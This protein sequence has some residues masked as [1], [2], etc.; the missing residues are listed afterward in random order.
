MV[1]LKNM[2]VF[3]YLWLLITLAIFSSCDDEEIS[4][5][6][7]EKNEIVVQPTVDNVI[8]TFSGKVAVLAGSDEF[9]SFLQKR[10]PRVE[11]ELTDETDVILMNEENA[12]AL[13]E[14][15]ERYENLERFWY[16]NKIVAFIRPSANALAL[17][18]KLQNREKEDVSNEMIET[19]EKFLVYAAKADGN[20]YSYDKFL[21]EEDIDVTEGFYEED[22]NGKINEG[23][24]QGNLKIKYVFNDFNKGQIAEAICGWLNKYTNEGRSISDVAFV[25]SGDNSMAS[26]PEAVTYTMAR[27]ITVNYT[28]P[29]DVNHIDSDGGTKISP[30][31]VIANHSASIIAVYDQTNDR[32]LYDV[33]FNQE[34]DAAKTAQIDVVVKKKAKYKW[35]YTAGI[36]C[37][38]KVEGTLLCDDSNFK[39]ENVALLDPTP[40]NEGG[41]YT[42]THYPAQHTIGASIMSSMGLSAGASGVNA[43]KSFGGSFSYSCTLP[44]E[45]TTEEYEDMKA[46]YSAGNGTAT[47]NYGETHWI[48]KAVWGSNAKYKYPYGEICRSYC[49]TDQFVI[50]GV[51]NSRNLEKSA[52]QLK[53]ET[54]W[55]LYEECAN[56]WGSQRQRFK[57]F[58]QK[59]TFDM[60]VVY[61]YFAK[62]RPECYYSNVSA[63]END[64][65]NINE[66]LVANQ[67]YKDF[68]DESLSVGG[69]TEEEVV[70]NA[71]RMWNE[72]ITSMAKQFENGLNVPNSHYIIT[73]YC[74]EDG[75]RS[76]KGLYIHDDKVE[77]VDDAKA[78]VEELKA[79]LK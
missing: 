37:G 53:M 29:W 66:W 60:P 73:L 70:E 75:I 48:Y 6:Y 38:P 46:K 28:L 33:E 76:A 57:P 47:W 72:A 35:K 19:F 3:K 79:S 32:D 41:K 69:R 36:Y 50:Y 2:N 30:V 1:K 55:N 17:L 9:L 13:L 12:K 68:C 26:S 74:S 20:K 8:N 11:T 40:R 67:Y 15:P 78:K 31:T 52:V 71:N 21:E 65:G 23:T 43:E 45:A 4:E 51:K 7:I 56:P 59:K 58:S 62:Y 44:Y 49:N 5:S 54:T 16:Q 77:I 39:P 14:N 27:S 22:E 42:V 10:F 18:M 64:W 34:F 25:R 63:A 24:T 61:R